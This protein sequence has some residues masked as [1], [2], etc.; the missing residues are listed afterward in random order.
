MERFRRAIRLA[1]WIAAGLTAVGP[2]PV[3]ADPPVPDPFAFPENHPAVRAHLEELRTDRRE[4]FQ[5]LLDRAGPYLP[6][7]RTEL[8]RA[9]LPE[10]LSYLPLIESGFSNRA[11]SPVGA[12]GMWQL[13][14]ETARQ[15]G[16][17]VDRFRDD[18]RDPRKATRAAAEHLSS[19]MDRFGSPLL[20]LAAYNAG[21]GRISGGL[22]RLD[23]GSA[24]RPEEAFF[25][26]SEASLLSEETRRYVPRFLAA[27]QI[28]RDPARFGFTPPEI[29][30]KTEGPEARDVSPRR[31]RISLAVLRE[32]FDARPPHRPLPEPN[33][34]LV[35]REETLEAIAERTGVAEETIRRI[36]LL[37]RGYRLR[38][39]Q[40]L[41]M[42]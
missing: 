7:I 18:R 40:I 23:D 14:P 25:R 12:A 24:L 17:R 8:A 6:M 19:L 11:V 37:P 15:Y 29:G 32:R 27:A 21:E 20:A 1:L 28:A 42:P 35:R 34:L 36:N 4:T 16:L 2:R 41:R 26:L 39:G 10:E 30:G 33:H 38:P 5:A 31:E 9:D 22:D 13:M 3:A